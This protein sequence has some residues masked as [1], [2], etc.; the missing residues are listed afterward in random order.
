MRS[1]DDKATRGGFTL[2]E[3]LITIAILGVLLMIGV[4]NLRGFNEKYKV[5]AET[6]QLYR[7]SDGRPRACDAAEPRVLCAGQW[8]RLPRHTRTRSPAPDGDGALQDNGHA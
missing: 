8:G 3:I 2:V 4:S 5:E 6:K 7:G 1:T